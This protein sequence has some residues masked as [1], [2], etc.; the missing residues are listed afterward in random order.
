MIPWLDTESSAEAR[1]RAVQEIATHAADIRAG[2]FWADAIAEARKDPPERLRQALENLPLPAAFREAAIALRAQIRAAR[3]SGTPYAQHLVLL[4]W[5]AA[6]NSLWPHWCDRIGHGGWNVL[7]SI[8][9]AA[10]QLLPFDYLNLG[11]SK[12]EL[13]TVT[14]RK[15]L[16]EAWGEPAAHRTLHDM[17]RRWWEAYEDLYLHQYQTMLRQSA[18]ELTAFLRSEDSVN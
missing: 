17:H 12:L 10:I 2:K 13:L 7:S 6:I 1:A 9:G 16:V 8:P 14:D 3:K 18:A 4:Y 11:Y 5:L 15:W